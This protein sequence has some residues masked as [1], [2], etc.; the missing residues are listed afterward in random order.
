MR[1]VYIVMKHGWFGKPNVPI[2]VCGTKDEYY[3]CIA[4]RFPWRKTW[5]KKV[6]LFE[7]FR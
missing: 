5:L 7:E 1:D 4:G 2:A 3:K 6:K